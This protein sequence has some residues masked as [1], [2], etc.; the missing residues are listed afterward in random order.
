MSDSFWDE[1]YAQPEWAYGTEPNDF[2]REM[3][4]EIP[5]GPV[6]SL[7]EG[8]G[9]NAVHLAALGHAVTAVDRSPVGLARARELAGSRRVPITTLE[10][11][12][13][14]FDPG[15]GPWSA[16]ISIFCHIP[17]R[18]QARL[19]PRLAE[20]L[21]P[22]GVLILEAYTPRQLGFSTGGPREPDLLCSLEGLRPLLRGL[23][24][25]VGREV[26]REVREGAHHQG[27]SAV[28]Q[29]RARRPL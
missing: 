13:E 19:Y 3:A 23:I 18:L 9:R 29:V 25:E 21:A 15:P 26:D 2:L 14:H 7:G 24:L 4:G 28:V 27:L 11:D 16:I 12:L 6:L 17:S 1:R 10:A 5:A 22:G 8:Q 20:V